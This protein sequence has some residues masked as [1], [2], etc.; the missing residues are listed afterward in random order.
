MSLLVRSNIEEVVTN[1]RTLEGIAFKFDLPSWVSDGGP[2][3]QE[4]MARSVAD[5]LDVAALHFYHPF[6]Q[7][8]GL[9]PRDV[10]PFGGVQ[11]RSSD[12]EQALVFEAKVSETRRGDEM[13]TLLND[14]A[15][16]RAVSVGFNALKSSVKGRV[17]MREAIDIKELSL[18]PRGVPGAHAGAEILEVRSELLTPRLDKLRRK[19][20][21]L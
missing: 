11:F 12:D 6:T 20:I 4:A 10:E 17:T 9:A 13:L 1:G 3:Y 21:L 7:L 16:G 8:P 5:G 18:L 19:I 2:K 14:G 15:L